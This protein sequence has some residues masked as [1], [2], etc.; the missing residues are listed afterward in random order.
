MAKKASWHHN[1]VSDTMCRCDAA[2][3]V[4]E[5]NPR[6]YH[7][8]QALT[9]HYKCGHISPWQPMTLLHRIALWALTSSVRCK[10]RT[11]SPDTLVTSWGHTCFALVPASKVLYSSVTEQAHTAWGC[12]KLSWSL[13]LPCQGWG[14]YSQV[15]SSTIQLP[16]RAKS[17]KQASL[18]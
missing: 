18:L 1:S 2:G 5:N 16:C 10:S 9:L 4:A 7:A 13:L 15:G 12:S 14:Q 17:T 6:Q 8:H 3:Q 11:Q